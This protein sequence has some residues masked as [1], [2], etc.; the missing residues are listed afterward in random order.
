MDKRWLAKYGID[1]DKIAGI[2]PFSGHTITHMTIR[3]E[4]KISD[5]RPQIDEF[6]PLYYVRPDAP[7]LILITGDRNMELLGRYEENAYM[8]RMM[9]VAGHQKTEL[10]EIQGHDHGQ[11]LKPAMTILLNHIKKD[12]KE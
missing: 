6:A 9:K 3:E 11:M 10:Y 8:F 4:R 2:I 12:G 1:A 7:P 5:K